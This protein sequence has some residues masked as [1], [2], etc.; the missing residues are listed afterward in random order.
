[1]G[2]VF[3][4]VGALLGFRAISSFLRVT[5]PILLCHLWNLSP[6]LHKPLGEVSF[7]DQSPSF[8]FDCLVFVQ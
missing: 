1:M 5:P 8:S 2:G 3:H 4:A 7:F 6:I